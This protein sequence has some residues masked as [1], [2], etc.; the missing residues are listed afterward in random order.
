MHASVTAVSWL[1]RPLKL[2]QHHSRYMSASAQDHTR[3]GKQE[4]PST[5]LELL[6]QLVAEEEDDAETWEDAMDE[7]EDVWMREPTGESFAELSKLSA[8]PSD[9][10]VTTVS[11]FKLFMQGSLA[12]QHHM[13]H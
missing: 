6:L 1:C 9:E 11:S 7:M 4:L 12:A 3:P 13:V 5:G 8:G 10:M 2:S